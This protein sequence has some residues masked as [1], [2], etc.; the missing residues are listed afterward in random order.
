MQRILTLILYGLISALIVISFVLL[1]PAYHN[2]EKM[3][4]RVNELETQLARKK[5][6]Y[7]ELRQLL[8]DLKHNPKAV[9]KVARE[10][11]GLCKKDEII[12]T[13]DPDKKTSS[14]PDK[15]GVQ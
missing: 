4:T 9:E 1:L 6:E 14:I 12:Y 13:Y 10:K 15:H 2:L 5:A 7:L 8:Y 3:K 11:F